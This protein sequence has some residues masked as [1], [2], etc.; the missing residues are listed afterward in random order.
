MEDAVKAKILH[1]KRKGV[2]KLVP[3]PMGGGSSGEGTDPDSPPPSAWPH[4]AAAAD[5]DEAKAEDE[6][7]Y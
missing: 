6:V 3:S 2:M 4:S 7:E 5:G 1:H